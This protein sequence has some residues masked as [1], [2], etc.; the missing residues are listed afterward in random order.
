MGEQKILFTDID[1]TLLN[2]AREIPKENK[3]AIDRAVAA[4]H[5]VVIATG[6]PLESAKT[7]VENLGLMMPGCYM[8]AYN[9]AIIYD[10]GKDKILKKESLPYEYVSYLMQRA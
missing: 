3:E 10:C 9:G 5:Y 8:I 4:G 7:V 1:G 6:R 2:D